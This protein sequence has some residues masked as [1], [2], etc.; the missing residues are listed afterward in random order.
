VVFFLAPAVVQQ[1]CRP[2]QFAVYAA[3][4]GVDCGGQPIGHL[5]YAHAMGDNG[6]IA[7][8]LEGHQMLALPRRGELVVL[9]AVL[10]IGVVGRGVHVEDGVL[11]EV[12]DNGM[13]MVTGEQERIFDPFYRVEGGDIGRAAGTG[14]GLAIV[15]HM[16]AAHDGDV[17]VESTE[18]EGST[19][20][21]RLPRA[22]GKGG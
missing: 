11:I 17:F 12:Q 6:V 5:R 7:S 19:F 21:I 16:V 8:E 14:L 2:Q 10:Q 20:S 13:G 1:R 22:S 15:R 18:G 4:D 3:L 9:P